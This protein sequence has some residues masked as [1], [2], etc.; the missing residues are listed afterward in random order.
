MVAVQVFNGD[1]TGDKAGDNTGDK[2]G[3]NTCDKVG[4]ETNVIVLGD[5]FGWRM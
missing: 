1:N 2:A 3:D 5:F 4:G